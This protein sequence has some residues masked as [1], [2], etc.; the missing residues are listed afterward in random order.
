MCDV[1]GLGGG[2]E[3][4]AK[5]DASRGLGDGGIMEIFEA[6]VDGRTRGL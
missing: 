2:G 1:F 3:G 6:V 5:G 4:V